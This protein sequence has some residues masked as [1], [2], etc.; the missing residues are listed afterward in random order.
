MSPNSTLCSYLDM[1]LFLLRGA[2]AVEG[3][4]YLTTGITGG[5]MLDGDDSATE[6]VDG[7]EISGRTTPVTGARMVLDLVP[8]NSIPEEILTDHPDRFRAM[9]VESANPAHSLTDTKRVREAFEALE[10]VVVIDVAMTE[11]AAMADY[12]LPASSQYEK[13]EATFYPH[14]FPENFFH[15]RKPLMPPYPA[16]FRKLKSTRA[17]SKPQMCLRLTSSMN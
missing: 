10:F 7:Y 15:L 16:P 6:V 2:F 8:C 5:Y 3:G 12:I 9:I 14:E 4:N 17:Y 1:L 13:Y 11:T